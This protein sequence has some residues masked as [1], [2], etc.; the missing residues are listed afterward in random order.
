MDTTQ[1]SN[2]TNAASSQSAGSDVS[3]TNI[4]KELGLEN[5]SEEEKAKI[6]SDLTS[7]V[8]KRVMARVLDYLS[9][10]EKEEMGKL[11]E[12]NPEDIDAITEWLKEKVPGVGDIV[13]E[14]TG[15]V[16]EELVSS[17]NL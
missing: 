1:T 4:L 8:Q 2:Q 15:K 16:K 17:I 3:S 6:L 13:V 7:L 14:E 11:L 9:D 10:E 12:E 5:I